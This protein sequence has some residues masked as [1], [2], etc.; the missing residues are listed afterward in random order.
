MIQRRRRGAATGPDRRIRR[1]PAQSPWEP[2]AHAGMR[3]PTCGDACTGPPARSDKPRGV[4]TQLSVARTATPRAAGAREENS[5]SIST[6]YQGQGPTG[7]TWQVDQ[8]VVRASPSAL[9]L[10]E[11]RHMRRGSARARPAPGGAQWG[12]YRHSIRPS[13]SGTSSGPDCVSGTGVDR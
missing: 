9:I 6:C 13:V 2:Y 4:A 10:L 11:C 3:L 8:G 12:R 7:V 1:A 5:I